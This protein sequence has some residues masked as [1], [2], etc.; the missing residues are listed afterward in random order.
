MIITGKQ[1][2]LK[3]CVRVSKCVC[4]CVASPVLEKGRGLIQN[5][6]ARCMAAY[7]SA[8]ISAKMQCHFLTPYFS[9]CPITQT[10]PYGYFW[11]DSEP[12]RVRVRRGKGVY[13]ATYLPLLF[14][15]YPSSPLINF[16]LDCLA[17][18]SISIQCPWIKPSYESLSSSCLS[19]TKFQISFCF[20]YH[21]WYWGSDGERNE[22]LRWGETGG[23]RR[24]G[25]GGGIRGLLFQ[26]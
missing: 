8:S 17:S 24:G 5:T 15:L 19:N 3:K 4:V 6:A 18:S 14:P 25:G 22:G 7:I 11:W 10:T 2:W 21:F 16:Q 1:T 23:C 9:P 12:E 13:G 20:Q 26:R